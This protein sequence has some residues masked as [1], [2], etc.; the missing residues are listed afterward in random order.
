MSRM[1]WFITGVL[2][3]A[4]AVAAAPAVAGSLP[5]PALRVYQLT[6][7]PDGWVPT[8]TTPAPVRLTPAA[9]PVTAVGELGWPGEVQ[10]WNCAPF[11]AQVHLSHYDPMSGPESCWDYDQE[12]RYCYSPTKPGLA[13]KG[14]WGIAAACPPEWPYGTWVVVPEAGAYICLDRGGLIT[15]DPDTQV[16]NVDVLGP[17]GAAWDGRIYTATLWVPL[18]PPRGNP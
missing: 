5:A 11:T 8:P 9:N 4:M 1:A 18:D 13:W 10:C 7:A 6:P 2:L 17:G 15:C 14:L 3:A 16:C 12:Q